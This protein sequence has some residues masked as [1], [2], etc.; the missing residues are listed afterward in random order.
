MCHPDCPAPISGGSIDEATIE[1]A[2]A[3]ET[4]IPAFLARPAADEPAP[5]VVV[6]HDINGANDFYRDLARRLAT[7]G[8]LAILPDFFVREGPPA[9]PTPE[10]VR[11]RAG[12]LDQRRA[13]RDLAAA[14][15]AA[16]D[17][18]AGNGRVGVIGFCLGGTMVL[19]AAAQE[20]RPDA[21]VAYYGFPVRPPTERA[22]LRPI[23]V[24][25]DV[26]APA[27][28]FWGDDDRA[29]GMENVETYRTALTAAGIAHDVTIYPGY[30]HGFLTFDPAS[31]WA[32]GARDSWA[33][34]VRFFETH[35]SI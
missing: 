31:P 7:E 15:A 18:P 35:L 2:G 8:Y 11:E 9:A 23:D 17:H 19:L 24:A 3:E 21:V 30:P 33:K 34:T 28:A 27:I 16:R 14:Q 26:R 25:A 22:P 5:A 6:V 4:A 13:L 32:E 12:R 10:A 20:N 1:I 29:V